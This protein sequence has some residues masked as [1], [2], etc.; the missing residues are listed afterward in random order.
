MGSGWVKFAILGSTYARALQNR[1]VRTHGAENVNPST[2][3]ATAAQ[4]QAR[5]DTDLSSYAR[6]RGALVP[7]QQSRAMSGL[8]HDLP[9][10]GEEHQAP[11]SAY[12]AANKML[13]ARGLSH[14]ARPP[15]TT[16]HQRI[17]QAFGKPTEASGGTEVGR[18]RLNARPQGPNPL[19]HLDQ[20]QHENPDKPRNWMPPAGGAAV[21]PAQQQQQT[22]AQT[23]VGSMSGWKPQATTSPITTT[24]PAGSPSTTQLLRDMRAEHAPAMAAPG[25]A[26]TAVLTK[27]PAPNMATQV[28]KAGAARFKIA[29][30][31]SLM[32]SIGLPLAVGG[33][34]LLNKPGIKADIAD[35]LHGQG[36]IHQKDVAQAIP[37]ELQGTAARAAQ[38]L[39]ERGIDPKAMRFAVD[40]PSG[41]GKTVLSKALA[42][43][44]GLQHHGLDW[45]PH[46]RLHQLMGGGD[47][48]K[49]PYTPHAGEVLE[50]Q[51]LLR[52]YDPEMFDVALHI[53]KDPNTIKQQVL[54]RGRGARTADLLDYDKSID[55]GRKA[56]E[57]LG[58]EPIDLGG[59]IIMKVR[60]QEGWGNQL[61][62]RLAQQ[63]IDATGLTRHQKLLSLHS[64]KREEH[65]AGWT[66][67]IKNPFSGAETSALGSTGPLGASIAGML[68][69][70]ASR[71]S[72]EREARHTAIAGG[73]AVGGHLLKGLMHRATDALVTKERTPKN[74]ENTVQTFAKRMLPADAENDLNVYV[75]PHL[76]EGAGKRLLN[77]K[78][79]SSDAA[80]AH[81]LGHVSNY[82]SPLTKWRPSTVPLDNVL[83]YTGMGATG[84]GI[85]AKHPSYA[86]ALAHLAVSSP[87][88]LDEGLASLRAS[89]HLI[90]E[91]GVRGLGQALSLAFPFGTY[92]LP[93]AMPLGITALKRH[94]DDND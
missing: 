57:T 20:W 23:Q 54:K 24:R 12:G 42:Q 58:G 38:A 62:Q 28:L 8:A 75:G 65:G 55:V 14:N 64:G 52:S 90:S 77:L 31:A 44:M 6:Q 18:A 21:Q 47:I 73:A 37:E 79:T 66:P 27:R 5:F 51:Q 7:T 88:L 10:Q 15:E 11:V 43:Q 81:E 46:L 76:D 41:A 1:A 70:Q 78:P 85:M 53:H 87:R 50:H 32:T 40:A 74:L 26:S 82:E 94:L 34:M 67:Y 48:E 49:M 91:H 17:E 35:R 9:W 71:R 56:F 61:E 80:V 16:S 39:A 19:Q 60:P 36:D 83:P 4:P 84:Y 59:G 92:A 25:G 63:G 33:S 2:F 3:A 22:H 69:K 72:D 45:R 68:G 13:E 29:N 89:K 30:P 93:A 86:P